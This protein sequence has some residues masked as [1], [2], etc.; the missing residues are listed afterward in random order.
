MPGHD[1][2]RRL[3]WALGALA[4]LVLGVAGWAAFAPFVS[5]SRELSYVI[6]E[7]TATRQKADASFAVLPSTI[8]LTL[9]VQ[10]V[11]IVRNEDDAT[12]QLGPILLAP[13]QTYR[14][15]FRTP[16]RFQYACSLHSSGQLTIV[17][18]PTPRIG[19][20]RLLWRLARVR[21]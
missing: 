21:A 9:G 5:G 4:A 12:H 14:I 6:P 18:E 1:R 3:G 11:L 20:E 17:V 16:S 19:A 10:D 2:R 15:P 13:R 7:G 8:R